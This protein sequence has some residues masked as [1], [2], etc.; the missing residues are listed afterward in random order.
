M[1]QRQTNSTHGACSSPEFSITRSQEHMLTYC[2]SHHLGPLAHRSYPATCVLNNA[3]PYGD[4]NSMVPFST[5][6]LT[7]CVSLA[8][9]LCKSNLQN[10]GFS[11]FKMHKHARDPVK[12][13]IL[14]QQV[15][16][17]PFGTSLKL[18]GDAM[19][20]VQGPH[21]VTRSSAIPELL[22]YLLS[23]VIVWTMWKELRAW[24]VDEIMGI[25][26]NMPAFSYVALSII[27]FTLPCPL[28]L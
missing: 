14:N 17:C 22:T 16:T 13:H 19:L 15:W 1:R 11:Q 7:F 9:R 23:S 5:V 24:F 20:L 12:T 28:S 8:T 6:S 26:P 2:S 21:W 27:T 25:N 18:P 4:W 3:F 10:Q